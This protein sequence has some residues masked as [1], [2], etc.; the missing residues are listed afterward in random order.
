[1]I[2]LKKILGLANYEA[3]MQ[4]MLDCVSHMHS[5]NDLGQIWLL[6]HEHVI[7]LG[8]AADEADVKNKS[9]IPVI[10]ANRGGKVTYHGPGQRVIYCML[11][12]KR[13][14]NQIDV[15]RFVQDM[16]KWGVAAL[17]ICGIDAFVIDGKVG[18]WVMHQGM[19]KKIGSI[20]IRI[21]KGIT[22]HGMAINFNTNI[23]HFDSI[24]SCGMHDCV[25][26]SISMLRENLSMQNL[27]DALI[28]AFEEVF[29]QRISR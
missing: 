8:S 22:Y 4:D 7:T 10:R 16:E 24:V 26:C 13:L 12:L 2:Q 28:L 5:S 14:Y 15:R 23:E 1:M 17:R 27:D 18:L 9:D 11:N 21:S 6:E 3:C 25:Q 20:G 19:Q 29:N